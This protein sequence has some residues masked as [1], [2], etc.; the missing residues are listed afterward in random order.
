MTKRELFLGV[1]NTMGPSMPMGP[2]G[3]QGN[4]GPRLLNAQTIEQQKVFHQQ[5]MLRAQQAAMQQQMVRPPPPDYKSSAGM[6][7]GIQP[8]YAT[9]PPNI[10]RMPHQTMPP[11][12]KI[13]QQNCKVPLKC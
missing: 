2:M 5:Q 12:G 3:G 11:S 9:A 1:P 13:N 8:R 10:R 7:Q 4:M 6:L